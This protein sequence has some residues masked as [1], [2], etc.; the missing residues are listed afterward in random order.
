VAERER[1]FDKEMGGKLIAV[2]VGPGDSELLTLKA[3]RLIQSATLLA[4]AANEKGY[5]FAREI[6]KDLIKPDIREL[7]LFFS[8]DKDRNVRVEERKKAVEQL[9]KELCC[10]NSVTYIS[11]GDPL[12]YSTF[13]HLLEALPSD[14]EVEICPGISAYQSA[15]AS[16]RLFLI[17]EN[18][19]MVIL[20]AHNISFDELL[21]WLQRDN[22]VVLYKVHSCLEKISEALI[23]TNRLNNAVLIQYASMD[24]E[25]VF[26]L[27]S[28][29][30]INQKLPY[31]SL[32]IVPSAEKGTK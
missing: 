11:E 28:Y 8:M 4:Y 26:P 12:T 7:P 16:A 5:S 29:E 22:T 24:D 27:K 9:L 15:A 6:V 1:Y 31:F 32:V 2:G 30:G 19:Q 14:V 10:N 23:K 3:K 20:S 13:I 18:Q 17:K 21:F 25:K